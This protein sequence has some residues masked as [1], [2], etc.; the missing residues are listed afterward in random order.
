MGAAILAAGLA[1]SMAQNV[2]S[3]NVVGYVNVSILGGHANFMAN[4][5][6]TPHNYLDEVLPA[7]TVPAGSTVLT[8]NRISATFHQDY[9]DGVAWTDYDSGTPTGTTTLLPPGKGFFVNNAGGTVTNTFV[10]EVLQGTL[11]V[12]IAQNFNAIGSLTPTVL[13]L[14]S[15]GFPQVAGLI[16]DDYQ[17]VTAQYTQLYNDG[18]TGW[19]DYNSGAPVQFAPAIGTGFFV[20]NSDAANHD[21][22]RNFT[23]Q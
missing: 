1:S 15:N 6:N 3:L 11:T 14:S 12:P 16:I 20:V 22:T 21:W 13:N 18:L 17:P 19:Q 10:G 2:Y 8:W 9:S 23:V 5:L 4:P 7:S